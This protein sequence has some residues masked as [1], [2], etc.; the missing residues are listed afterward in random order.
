M[1]AISSSHKSIT[2][3]RELCPMSK[4]ILKNVNICNRK[5]KFVRVRVLK[6]MRLNKAVLVKMVVSKSWFKGTA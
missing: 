2:G 5:P 3:E 4:Q 1:N 6:V